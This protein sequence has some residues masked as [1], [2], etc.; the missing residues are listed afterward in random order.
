MIRKSIEDAATELGRTVDGA[1]AGEITCLTRDGKAAAVVAS[2]FCDFD[3]LKL[4][5]AETHEATAPAETPPVARELRISRKELADNWS[6]VIWKVSEGIVV[7]VTDNDG[8]VCAGIVPD[9]GPLRE[10]ALAM[11]DHLARFRNTAVAEGREVQL[12]KHSKLAARIVPPVRILE[13]LPGW[14]PPAP[15]LSPVEKP[16]LRVGPSGELRLQR[17]MLAHNWP[18][19]MRAI[20]RDHAVVV[21]EGDGRIHGAVVGDSG[22][23]GEGA[24]PVGT[25]GHPRRNAALIEG[26]EAQITRF[27]RVV[28]RIVPESR[29][30]DFLPGWGRATPVAPSE[31]PRP[32]LL[33]A[34][35]E[36]KPAPKA[37]KPAKP[38]KA[39]PRAAEPA[40][41]AVVPVPTSA[42]QRRQL[43]IQAAERR[44]AG[45]KTGTAKRKAPRRARSF[46]DDDF[47][48]ED[49]MFEEGPVSLDEILGE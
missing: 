39:A 16:V 34:V 30:A 2:A 27:G 36:A 28:A 21:V 35:S 7:V 42:E 18:T 29:I 47:V 33:P 11:T 43:I 4:A 20:E 13:F 19:V 14:M 49:E 46:N 25:G 9:P 8:K 44:Q 37:T 32:K 24:I 38:A 31:A 10:G 45:E 40:K 17:P 26:R 3:A 22:P 1:L 48:K 5:L 12:T 41:A 6:R 15:R 23:A